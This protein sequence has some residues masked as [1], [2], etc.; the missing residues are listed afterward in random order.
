MAEIHGSRF[1]TQVVPVSLVVNCDFRSGE[2]VS[3]VLASGDVLQTEDLL[4]SLVS[5]K[6]RPRP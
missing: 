1:E 6:M 4:L 3:I 5:A 2:S